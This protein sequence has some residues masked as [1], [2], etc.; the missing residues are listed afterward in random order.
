MNFL[1]TANAAHFELTLLAYDLVN[2]FRRLCLSGSWQKARLKTLRHEVFMLPARLVNL[3]RRNVLQL[4]GSYP[5]RKRFQ[6]A[7]A[8]VRRLRIP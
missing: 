8:Q 2:W 1:F 7:V 6:K 3:G 4:P 5:H